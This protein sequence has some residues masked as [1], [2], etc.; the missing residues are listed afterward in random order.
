[1][2]TDLLKNPTGKATIEALH[3][4]DRADWSGHFEHDA[5]LYDD[6][7]SPKITRLDIG[8]AK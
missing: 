3:K 4:G 1:M 5:K 2:N 7:T 6:G 8:Q